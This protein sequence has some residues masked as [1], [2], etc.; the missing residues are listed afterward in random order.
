MSSTS[1]L[2]GALRA[3]RPRLVAAVPGRPLTE[4]MEL[5]ADSGDARWVTH[6][7]VAFQMA[8]GAAAGGGVG[9]AMVKQ[10]GLNAGMD[11]FACAAPHRTGGAVLFVVGDD[12]DVAHSQLAGDARASAWI[13]EMPCVEPAG[14]EDLPAAVADAAELSAAH[15]VPVTLRVTAPLL[16]AEVDLPPV[17]RSLP[18]APFGIERTWTTDCFGQR[19]RLQEELAAVAAEPGGTVAVA[20]DPSIRLVAC[21]MPAAAASRSGRECLVVRRPVPVPEAEIAAF[22]AASDAPILVLEDGLPFVEGAVARHA[23]GPVLGR[24]SGHVPGVGAVDPAEVVD[25]AARGERVPQAPPVTFLGERRDLGGYGT[26]FED[27]RALDLVPAAC[28]AGL[29]YSAAYLPGGIAPFTYGL[30]S[31]IGVAAGIAADR[32][33]AVAV[34]GD[35][36][37]YH[38][39]ASALLQIARDRAP[40][41]VVTLDNGVAAYTGGQPHPGSAPGPGQREIP[42]AQ[43]AGGAGLDWVRTVAAKEAAAG[44]LRPLIEAW[45]ANPVPGML[46]I[47]DRRDRAHEAR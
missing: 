45:S 13:A 41:L 27:L 30:G 7:A 37:V 20:G 40:V 43:L 3:L 14:P 18:L 28:D 26:L 38:A 42:L 22:A 4:A 32:G 47:D 44:A 1:T 35:M 11:V 12:P 9:I 10:V 29:S 36:G 6:E 24:T 8:L 34:I 33:R 21:G 17:E 19:V 25:A 2:A 46:V 39:G 15:G 5:L 16:A 23:R 31:A